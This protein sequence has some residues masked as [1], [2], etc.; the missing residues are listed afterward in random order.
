M[1]AASVPVRWERYQC[2][3]LLPELD[4]I[5]SSSMCALVGCQRHSLWQLF[6]A[7][8]QGHRITLEQSSKRKTYTYTLNTYPMQTEYIH[9]KQRQYTHILYTQ[10]QKQ[11]H[12][13]SQQR[14]NRHT[15]R[16]RHTPCHLASQCAGGNCGSMLLLCPPFLGNMQHTSSLLANRRSGI[17]EKQVTFFGGPQKRP[18]VVPRP[19]I[20]KKNMDFL[21]F[22]NENKTVFRKRAQMCVVKTFVMMTT[23]RIH[24]NSTKELG[25]WKKKG[26]ERK[27]WTAPTQTTTTW[28][29]LHPGPRQFFSRAGSSPDRF[30]PD[31]SHPHRH[32]SGPHHFFPRPAL[33]SVFLCC[34]LEVLLCASLCAV[35]LCFCFVLCFCALLCAL[36]CARIQGPSIL[37]FGRKLEQ[38][39]K[40]VLNPNPKNIKL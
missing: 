18:D 34:S 38:S 29:L 15:L 8:P 31:R 11:A 25:N 12:T 9:D 1:T 28:T 6:E 40:P 13:H 21:K 16:P 4:A 2:P 19:S 23:R 14:R 17:Q 3:N 22:E 33:R 5:A 30:H 26:R 7:T 32:H 36:W 37:N 27:T 20:S 24:R 10:T 35:L 39:P